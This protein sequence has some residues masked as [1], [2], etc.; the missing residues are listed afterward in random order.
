MLIGRR[1]IAGLAVGLA[2]TGL[3]SRAAFAADKEIV[4]GA[5][6]PMS[7]PAASSGIAAERALTHAT[8]IINKEGIQIG[9]DRYT[10]KIAI[11]DNKYIPAES[12]TN[13]EKMLSE[14][15]RYIYSIGSGN[16]VPIVDKTNA[17]KALQFSFASGKDHLTGPN[18][19]LSFRSVPTN[20]TAYAIYPWLKTAYPNVKR[21][22]HVNPSDEAGFTESEDRRAQ[23]EKA[24]FT[25]VAN[26]YFKRGATDFYPTA[27]RVLT[28]NPD[29]IDFGG[30][31]GRDQALGV[32]ALRELGYK[33]MIMVGYVDPKTFLEIAGPEGAEGALLSNTL[34]EPQTQVQKDLVDWYIKK[35]GPPF[36]AVLYDSWDPI[37]M[38]AEAMRKA[39]SIDPVVVA[40]SLR[41]LEWAGLFG[42]MKYGM[43][44]VYKIDCSMT[45]DIP[46]GVVKSGK[47]TYL[48][49]IPWPKGL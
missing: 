15:I 2:Y 26:E 44:S 18:L 37:F 42:T 30:S 47:P 13:A 32:K 17:A 5:N 38:L 29:F 31:I 24:G 9:P 34:I 4:V 19:P 28:S 3:S 11:Y 8:E 21:V 27:T 39:Q 10:L 49:T 48:T 22:A 35:Y 33:G 23:A 20:E 46:M 43:K 41:S 12:V 25:N 7:G 36:S 45:R 6:V 40:E 14:G 1:S 16:S